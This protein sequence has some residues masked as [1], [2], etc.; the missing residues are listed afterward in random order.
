MPKKNAISRSK[1][2]IQLPKNALN[3]IDLGDAFA[4]YDK[5]LLRHPEIFVKTPALEAA[6][7]DA[8]TK[9]F[10]VGRRGTGKTAIT[11]YLS[12]TRPKAAFQLHPLAFVPMSPAIDLNKLKD[13]RRKYFKSLVHC[14][15]RAFQLEVLRIWNEQHLIA[16]DDL[17]SPLSKERNYVEDEDFDMRLL[18]FMEDLFFLPR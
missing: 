12:T 10:F 6:S 14:F 5:L 9:C 16:F 3:R 4:E 7:N 18:T 11:Y 15:K 1:T 13:S 8:G 17:P 2:N